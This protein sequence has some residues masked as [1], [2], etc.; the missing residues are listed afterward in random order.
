VVPKKKFI[1]PVILQGFRNLVGKFDTIFSKMLKPVL[2]FSWDGI[3]FREKKSNGN[4]LLI[5]Y[6]YL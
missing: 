6:Q 5:A 4:V 1:E 2:C 3:P